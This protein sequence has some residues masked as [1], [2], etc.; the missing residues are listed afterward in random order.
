[1]LQA[2]KMM[3]RPAQGEIYDSTSSAVS[4]EFESPAI[5]E[6]LPPRKPSDVFVKGQRLE[7]EEV[8]QLGVQLVQSRK[9]VKNSK[10][11]RNFVH[12][13]EDR[14]LCLVDFNDEPRGKPDIRLVVLRKWTFYAKETRSKL[15]KAA[16]SIYSTTK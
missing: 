9:E 4:V 16:Y 12:S 8:E 14:H 7:L 10:I 11:V 13:Y 6:V 2:I 15:S 3:Q 5:A 1:V